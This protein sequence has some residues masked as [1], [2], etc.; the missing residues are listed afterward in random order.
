M[1]S[2]MLGK[3][4]PGFRCVF[5]CCCVINR[6]GLLTP[7]RGD[8][9]RAGSRW[10]LADVLLTLVDIASR[11]QRRPPWWLVI[12][13]V[14]GVLLMYPDVINV[15]RMAFDAGM[16]VFLP[17]AWSLF[18][19]IRELWTLP[20]ASKEEKIRRRTLTFDRLWVGILIIGAAVLWTIGAV[21]LSEEG[22]GALAQPIVPVTVALAFYGIAAGTRGGPS[23]GLREAADHL[24]VAR[25]R[26]RYLPVTAL[27][28]DQRCCARGQQQRGGVHETLA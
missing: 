2:A 24:V 5:R 9:L 16:W 18:E 12:L 4:L 25:P 23:A 6:G 7:D 10:G 14:A 21:L 17:L 3:L 13:I 22:I 19:R 15:L 28:G 26:R 20:G 8:R 27:I 11:V 1:S